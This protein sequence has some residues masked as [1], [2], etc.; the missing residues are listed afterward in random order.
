MRNK[1]VHKKV[2]TVWMV[3]VEMFFPF[4][5]PGIIIMFLGNK[6]SENGNL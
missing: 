4:L 6:Y 3:E 1:I 5:F 2:K